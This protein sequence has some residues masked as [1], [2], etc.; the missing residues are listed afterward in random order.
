[1]LMVP[2]TRPQDFALLMERERW[3]AELDGRTVLVLR[4]QTREVWREHL[5]DDDVWRACPLP[6]HGGAVSAREV[7]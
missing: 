7:H 5:G 4:W 2:G 1:M 3:T 6:P